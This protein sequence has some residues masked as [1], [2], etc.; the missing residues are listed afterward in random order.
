MAKKNYP[1]YLSF[2]WLVVHAKD[3]R[4]TRPI[5]WAAREPHTFADDI[6]TDSPSELADSIERLRESLTHPSSEPGLTPLKF[7]LRQLEKEAFNRL[8]KTGLLKTPDDLW[9]LDDGDQEDTVELESAK[10]L[11]FR[12]KEIRLYLDSLGDG[13]SEVEDVLIEMMRLTASAIRMEIYEETLHGRY[14][15]K[16]QEILGRMH[17]EDRREKAKEKWAPVRA[18]AE[19]I[20]ANRKKDGKKPLTGRP[21]ARLLK[22][23]MKLKD[24]EE[25][26]RKMAIE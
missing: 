11:L 19:E 21:L 18:K 22:S 20:Q 17:G 14:A 10:D 3:G 24:P 25:T 26:I 16:K 8:H 13:L 4:K 6:A 15:D 23:R 2:D 5:P 9:L 7:L 12:A 1:K